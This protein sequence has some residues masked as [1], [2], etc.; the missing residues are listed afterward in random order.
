MSRIDTSKTVVT[1]L[2]GWAILAVIGI[3]LLTLIPVE[4]YASW[5][6]S[7]G[8][9]GLD[10]VWRFSVPLFIFL[11]GFGLT[12]K[13]QQV[14]FDLR[15]FWQHRAVKLLPL[16]LIWSIYLVAVSLYVPGWQSPAADFTWWQILLLGK[17]ELSSVLRPNYLSAVCFLWVVASGHAYF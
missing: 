10:Q 4:W 17:G 9:L 7:I 15:H 3:H 16:Y 12:Q 11:S 2:K 14:S 8:V 1:R 5:P 13:Y 6:W